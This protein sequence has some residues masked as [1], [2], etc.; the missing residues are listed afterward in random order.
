MHM[1][2]LRQAEQ[3]PVPVKRGA[4]VR[5]RA[6]KHVCFNSGRMPGKVLPRKKL[7]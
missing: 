4:Q 6:E 1:R 2:Q 5:E 3:H 7:R